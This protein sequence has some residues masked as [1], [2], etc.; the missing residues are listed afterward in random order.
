MSVSGM[1]LKSR[2]TGLLVDPRREW[3]AI[4][5]EPADVVWTYRH[6]IAIVA[7]IP[8]VALFLRFTIGAAP[9][10]GLSAA[11]T[12]YIVALASPM[13]AALVVEKLAPR[14]QSKGSTGQALKLVAYSTAPAWVAGV[15][16][17]LPGVGATATLAAVLF[18]IYL[19]ALGLPRLLHTPREQIVPF[20]LVCGIVLVAI[21]VLLT[22]VL[23]RS[24]S[25]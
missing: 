11:V 7:A 22:A 21:N 17:L 14:F 5:A 3:T 20:M 10:L 15:F 24:R 13:V 23:S 8:S 12:R 18:G 9:V 16:Y 1:N 2:L 19:F 4:A 25:F 6:F